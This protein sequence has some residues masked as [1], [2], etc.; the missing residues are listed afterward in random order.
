MIKRNCED[1]FDGTKEKSEEKLHG[2]NGSMTSFEFSNSI[3]C[4][5]VPW[6]CSNYHLKLK[7]KKKI[8]SGPMEKFLLV[9]DYVLLYVII[10]FL[11]PIIQS[12]FE[13]YSH[14]LALAHSL[15]FSTTHTILERKKK[16]FFGEI[17]W[18]FFKQI[19]TIL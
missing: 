15:V 17:S 7:K 16:T 3:K 5:A 18:F 4:V 19:S 10:E 14:H 9:N 8:T 2:L 6:Q 1:N 12:S 13:M 11:R